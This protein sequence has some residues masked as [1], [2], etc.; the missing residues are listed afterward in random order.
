MPHGD[1]RGA[2]GWAGLRRAV[3]QGAQGAGL[4]CRPGATR[5][6]A[7]GVRKLLKTV[8]L[9]YRWA[10][11]PSLRCAPAPQALQAGRR[12]PLRGR[13]RGGVG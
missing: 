7:G 11:P 9:R 13:L 5:P 4:G 3:F 6:A 2:R 1:A 12:G 8:P 10:S